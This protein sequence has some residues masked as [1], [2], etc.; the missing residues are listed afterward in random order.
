MVIPA[1]LSSQRGN[2][3]GRIIE[4]RGELPQKSRYGASRKDALDV[5]GI[6]ARLMEPLAPALC[7]PSRITNSVRLCI[8]WIAPCLAILAKR[9]AHPFE[10]RPDMSRDIG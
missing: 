2:P 4:F 10:E 9:S 3:A 1:S 8:F 7:S 5:R 6:H